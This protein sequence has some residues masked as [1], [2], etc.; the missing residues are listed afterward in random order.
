MTFCGAAVIV[1]NSAPSIPVTVN[2]DNNVIC[3]IKKFISQ[4]TIVDG[5]LYFPVGPAQK[6]S[7]FIPTGHTVVLSLFPVSMKSD[8]NT[9]S[10]KYL[11]KSSCAR[12]ELESER[13]RNNNTIISLILILLLILLTMLKILIRPIDKLYNFATVNNSGLK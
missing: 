10:V 8:L 9:L 11:P 2:E 13:A 12:E 5:I 6:G 3:I 1:I 4:I 7:S